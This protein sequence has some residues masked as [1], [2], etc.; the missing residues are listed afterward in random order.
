MHK[1]AY[2]HIWLPF[3][4]FST[5]FNET[6]SKCFFFSRPF[7][8]DVQIWANTTFFFLSFQG[9]T[10]G[11]K[12]QKGEKNNDIENND[13]EYDDSDDMLA[14][15]RV[16]GGEISRR[17]RY[18]WTVRLVWVC[19]GERALMKVTTCSASLLTPRLLASATHCFSES[20]ERLA[21]SLTCAR[22]SQGE[23][24][25]TVV[26]HALRLAPDP[27]AFDPVYLS[28]EDSRLISP[29]ICCISPWLIGGG[30]CR[31]LPPLLTGP[32]VGRNGWAFP[33]PPLRCLHRLIL[34]WHFDKKCLC[35]W[36]FNQTLVR[37]LFAYQKSLNGT[38]RTGFWVQNHLLNLCSS[39]VNSQRL[40][41]SQKAGVKYSN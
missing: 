2:K 9:G 14:S 24:T 10:E 33:G 7:E 40:L 29:I 21:V 16:I 13:I 36:I 4:Q 11:K 8:W 23:L 28:C 27:V 1:K 26:P 25:G 30:C 37:Y 41:C 12:T 38:F 3:F 17:G 31:L 39:A 19:L 6:L 5:D 35:V 20:L 22:S 32:F 34:K 15:D 18:P